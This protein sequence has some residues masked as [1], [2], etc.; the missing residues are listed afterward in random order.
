MLGIGLFKIFLEHF[1]ML[2]WANQDNML[3]GLQREEDPEST[4]KM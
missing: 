4:C 2:E 1:I 3:T